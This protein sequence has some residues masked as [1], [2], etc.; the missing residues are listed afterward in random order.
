MINHL[1]LNLGAESYNIKV[2][3]D[4]LI[5]NKSRLDRCIYVWNK[6]GKRIKDKIIISNIAAQIHQIL[7][8][9]M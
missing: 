3:Y 8:K 4:L 1:I 5:N 6:N 2:D 7:Y 9:K